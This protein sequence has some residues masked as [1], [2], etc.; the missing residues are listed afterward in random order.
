MPR[1]TIQHCIIPHN[2]KG[3][4]HDKAKYCMY[5]PS[6]RLGHGIHAI[7]SHFQSSTS[8]FLDHEPLHAC[9]SANNVL[10]N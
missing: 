2:T 8:F 1:Q 5:V 7:K 9:F 4:G 10:V 6:S 3:F